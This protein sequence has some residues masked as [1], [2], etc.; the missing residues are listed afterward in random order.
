M[1]APLFLL[2]IPD[3]FSFIKPLIAVLGIIFFLSGISLADTHGRSFLRLFNPNTVE[4]MLVAEGTL[5][6]AATK[7]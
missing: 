4:A 3:D 1:L 7:V 5:K 6:P 2:P